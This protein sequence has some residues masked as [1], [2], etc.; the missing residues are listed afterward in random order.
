MEIITNWPS[1]KNET[2]RSLD[3]LAYESG[4]HHG[5]EKWWASLSFFRDEMKKYVNTI[6][7]GGVLILNLL[8][9]IPDIRWIIMPWRILRLCTL[10]GL[11]L[12]HS[13]AHRRS[14]SM[15]CHKI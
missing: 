3:A 2:K 7:G 6:R 10:K 15:K 9:W 1:V 14:I 11:D 4:K 12:M 13:Y 8:F 5:Y